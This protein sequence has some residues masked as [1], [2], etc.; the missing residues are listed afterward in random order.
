LT[1]IATAADRQIF[2]STDAGQ[3]WTLRGL[4]PERFAS[5]AASDDAT[6]LWALS[7][8]A[9]GESEVQLWRSN[10]G[11]LHKLAALHHMTS[12]K[13]HATALTMI[14]PS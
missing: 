13:L 8:A 5:M 2:A 14:L 9:A 1:I 12:R 7:K 4:A 6:K 3:T 11:K 10:D